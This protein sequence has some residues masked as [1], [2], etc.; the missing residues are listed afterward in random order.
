MSSAKVIQGYFRGGRP[1]FIGGMQ[2]QAVQPQMQS[3]AAPL[4]G[5]LQ[6]IGNGGVS[7]PL[8]EPLQKKMETLF[9]MSF[10]DVRVHVGPEAPSIGALAF[11]KGSDIYFAPGQYDPASARGQQLIGHELAHVVQQRQGRVQNPLGAGV[12]V[13]QDPALEAEADAMGRRAA[14]LPPRSG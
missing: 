3:T 14:M 1:R 7:R 2:R 5:T 13:V 11:T 4:P 8:P 10:D 6:Q 9:G 12:A